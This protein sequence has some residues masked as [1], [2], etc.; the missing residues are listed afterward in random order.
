LADEGIALVADFVFN[1][2]SDEHAWA[3]RRKTGDPD[4]QDFYWVFNDKADTAV[5]QA[6]AGHLPR[7][8]AR[9]P[10]PGART[11]GKWVWTTFNSY[12]WD[13]NYRNPAVFRAMASR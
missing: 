1:H 6:P 4:Y 2:T 3:K 9:A 5:Y 8:C 10:S 13:L 7:A 12:Q 11:W